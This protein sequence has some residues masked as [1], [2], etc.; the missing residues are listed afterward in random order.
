MVA[1]T[2]FSNNLFKTSNALSGFFLVRNSP[3]DYKQ[4]FDFVENNWIN[5]AGELLA[6]DA[7][8]VPLFSRELLKEQKYVQFCELILAIYANDSTLGFLA[9]TIDTYTANNHQYVDNRRLSYRIVPEK[10]YK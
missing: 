4:K 10:N 2:S 8:A 3:P 6:F 1:G 7:L 5:E 9:V